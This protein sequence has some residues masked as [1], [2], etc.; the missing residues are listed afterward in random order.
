MVLLK[1]NA[2]LF[3]QKII[4]LLLLSEK[5]SLTFHVNFLPSRPALSG[6]IEDIGCLLTESVISVCK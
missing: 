1:F 6:S 3:S 2:A 4:F 5:I